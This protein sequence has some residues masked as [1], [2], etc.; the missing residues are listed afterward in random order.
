MEEVVGEI[1]LPIWWA[2]AKDIRVCNRAGSKARAE[3]VTVDTNNASH[4]TAVWVKCGRGIVCLGFHADAPIIIPSDDSG[5][6]V[7]D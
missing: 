2:E 1:A 6:V 3:N 4:R 5:V 7:E